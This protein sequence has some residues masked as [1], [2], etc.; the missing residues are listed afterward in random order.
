MINALYL[1]KHGCAG[2]CNKTQLVYS[3]IR[4]VRQCQGRPG[5]RV[6]RFSSSSIPP[7]TKAGTRMSRLG[8]TCM[9]LLPFQQRIHDAETLQV[10][11]SKSYIQSEYFKAIGHLFHVTW[12]LPGTMHR[13]MSRT[14]LP[15]L[16]LC[17]WC[18]VNQQ[19]HRQYC[20]CYCSVTGCLTPCRACL[21]GMPL[22]LLWLQHPDALLALWSL[23]CA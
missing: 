10:T 16:K 18:K 6:Q 12:K 11:Q 20:Y 22:R 13:E 21:R 14:A 3:H 8:Q 15:V 19:G 7:S 17:R 4:H 9:T 2:T 5:V 1:Q 23:P